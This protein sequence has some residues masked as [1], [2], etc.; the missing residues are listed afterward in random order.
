[1]E[2]VVVSN[3]SN[4]EKLKKRFKD[5]GVG[6][7]H[8][9]SD[10]DR[11]LTKAFI[12]GKKVFS[13]ISV[14]RDGNYLSLDYAEKAHALF[15][16]YNPIEIDPRISLEEKKKVMYEWWTTHFKLLIESGL[17]KR[18][19]EKIVESKKIQFRKGTLEFID[20]LYKNKIPLVILSSAGLG[21][22]SISMLLKKEGRLYDNI[23]IVSNLYEWDKNGNAIAIK[24]PIIHSFNKSETSLHGLP[25][26]S[27]IENR[28]NVLLLGDSIGDIGMSRGFDYKNLIKIGFL[29][30]DVQ[31][32]LKEFK[33]NFDIVILNDGNMDFVNE[34]LKEIL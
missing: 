33:K 10:F 5:E 26:F 25:F 16:K 15:N 2:N 24:E 12:N 28:K 3:Q 21:G 7:I 22:D 4:L 18:D 19:L 1:M 34:L 14:L 9:I 29:N 31:E 6:K 11:T 17:N 23:H 27:L 30:Y 8:I 32:N 20:N 13:V